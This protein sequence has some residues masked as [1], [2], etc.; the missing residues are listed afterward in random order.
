MLYYDYYFFFSNEVVVG[1][2]VVGCL[3]VL[4]QY[5]CVKNR[6]MERL[7]L[8]YSPKDLHKPYIISKQKHFYYTFFH[9]SLH[10]GLAQLFGTRQVIF[11]SEKVKK[12][13]ENYKRYERL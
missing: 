4:L 6:V 12:L 1:L 8:K 11:W 5:L 13:P 2:E 9:D 10:E 3:K 7:K